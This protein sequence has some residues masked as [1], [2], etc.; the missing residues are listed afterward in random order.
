LIEEQNVMMTIDVWLYG[1]LA[2]FGG[3]GASPGF[4]NLQRQLTEGSTLQDLL[5]SIEMPTEKRGI[6]FVNG[7]LSA[8]P[9][10]QPDLGMKLQDGDRVGFFHLRA[11][12]P[13]QY[14][15]GAATLEALDG[16]LRR[17]EDGGL[18]HAYDG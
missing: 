16:E 8:M 17:D 6:T 11:M 18:R 3:E 7:N 10:K 12:W 5:E 9:G 4:A 2:Q 13:Y 14:R 1:E 15:Q